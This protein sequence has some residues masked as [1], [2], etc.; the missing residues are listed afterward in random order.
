MAQ[1]D[2][3]AR[4]EAPASAA[5]L[6]GLVDQALLNNGAALYSLIDGAKFPG[7]SRIVMP[8]DGSVRLYSLLGETAQADALYAGPVLLWHARGKQCRLLAQLLRTADSAEFLSI[9]ASAQDIDSL[10][11]HMTWMTDVLHEDGTEWVM[12]YY[13]PLILSHWIE[14]LDADQRRL[15]LGAIH[16]W[17]FIG[18]GGTLRT[19]GAGDVGSVSYPDAPMK[20][21]GRQC[22]FLMCKSLPLQIMHQLESDDPLALAFIPAHSRYL[23]FARQLDRAESYGLEAPTDLKSYCLLSLMFGADFDQTE[24]VAETLQKLTPSDSFSVRI[25][26]WTPAQ[27]ASLEPVLKT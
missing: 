3:A 1:L 18:V 23:F 27:W 8:A 22:D 5:S 9:L 24:L 10:V 11:R 19:I 21:S 4:Q 14:V 16:Q 6:L 7:L 15:A 2:M 13:D 25:M 17:C 12:R 26:R 20:L